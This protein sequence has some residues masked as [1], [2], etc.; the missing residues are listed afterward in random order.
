MPAPW[1]GQN[2][3][4]LLDLVGLICVNIFDKVLTDPCH[5]SINAAAVSTG[6]N[7][8]PLWRGASPRDTVRVSRASSVEVLGLVASLA[9]LRQSRVLAPGSL[10]GKVPS[11]ALCI[12]GDI[13]ITGPEK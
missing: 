3:A 8:G 1:R 6:G 10:S 11:F 12:F 2:V 5:C 4:I 9:E 13:R 7:T